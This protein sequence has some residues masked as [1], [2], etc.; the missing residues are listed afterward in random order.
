MIIYLLDLFGVAVF[1]VAGA[2][3]AGKQ[4][5]DVFGVMVV[6]VI[7]AI[8]GGTLRDIILDM[9]VFW[10]HDTTYIRVACLSALL[11]FILAR[12]MSYFRF[13]PLLNVFDAFGLALFT[14]I[15]AQKALSAGLE[16][17]VAVIMGVMTGVA[18]GVIRDVICNEIPLIFQR[19]I[20]AVAAIAGATTYILLEPVINDPVRAIV[21]MSVTLLIRLLAIRYH[22]SLPVF[23]AA[24]AKA[25]K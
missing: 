25:R 9:D 6:A 5:L 17:M 15:G 20:Y 8:G 24:D 12:R 19:E 18:G 1:A 14:I 11:T 10:L 2:L 4:K 21:A 13:R 22:L 23:M 3:T 16:P 7:T